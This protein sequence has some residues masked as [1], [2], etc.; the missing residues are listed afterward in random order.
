MIEFAIYLAAAIFLGVTIA[1][2][3]LV[4]RT[5]FA[6]WDGSAW[7]SV[8]GPNGQGQDSF[9]FGVVALGPDDVWAVGWTGSGAGDERLALAV[10]QLIGAHF[11]RGPSRLENHELLEVTLALVDK[12][13]VLY[14]FYKGL[15]S[16]VCVYMSA[17]RRCCRL[18]CGCGR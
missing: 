1:G 15:G 18:R 6:H 9:L 12:N 5:L 10:M 7:R 17:H 3:V 2:H 13:S 4:F 8:A 11:V 14:G 16:C